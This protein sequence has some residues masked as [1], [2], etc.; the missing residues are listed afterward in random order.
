MILSRL[1]YCNSSLNC[2]AKRPH[3]PS[4]TELVSCT[5]N[6]NALV[7]LYFLTSSIGFWYLQEFARVMKSVSNISPHL[8]I[9]RPLNLCQPKRRGESSQYNLSNARTLKQAGV[10]VFF[11]CCWTKSSMEHGMVFVL[12]SGTLKQRFCM[13]IKK[14]NKQTNKHL[15]CCFSISSCSM[16]FVYCIMF[17]PLC[18]L[19]KKHFTNFCIIINLVLELSQMLL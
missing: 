18:N 14:P 2:T 3:P 17:Y 16:Y 8:F 7:R 6:T 5:S 12:R 11:F 1:D 19:W 4:E 10:Q 9:Q 15:L 13:Q